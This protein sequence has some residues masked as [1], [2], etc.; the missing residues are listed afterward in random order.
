MKANRRA[1]AVL[2]FLLAAVA[3]VAAAQENVWAS[4]GPTG[5]G[6]VG[7]L[8]IAGGV[9]YAA[10]ENGV[11][12]SNDGGATWQQSGLAGE[13]QQVLALPQAVF[14]LTGS[15]NKSQPK[16]FRV[17]RDGGKTWGLVPGLSSI[18]AA[19][20]DPWQLSTLYAG[21]ANGTIWRSSDA[22]AS[23]QQIS[24]SPTG[25]AAIAFEFDSRAIYVRSLDASIGSYRNYKSLD[26]G[27]SWDAIQSDLEVLTGGSA[28]GVVYARFVTA[29]GEQGFCRSADSAA[30][31]KCSSIRGSVDLIFEVPGSAPGE[32]S[33]SLA[34]YWAT[35]DYGLHVS[36]DGG[37]TWTSTAGKLGSSVYAIASDATGSLLLAGTSAGIFRS[38]DRGDSWTPSSAGLRLPMTMHSL[39]LDP[40]NPSTVWAGTPEAGV[41]RSSDGGLSWS[42]A[43]GQGEM[44]VERSLAV[45]PELSSTLYAWTTSGVS[46]SDDGGATWSSPSLPG[47]SSQ[48]SYFRNALAVDPASSGRVWAANWS[49]GLFRS[50]DGARTWEPR[51]IAQDVFC[52]LFDEKRPGTIYLGSYYDTDYN[53]LSGLVGG[54]IF[55]SRDSG[56]SFTKFTVN[57]GRAFGND[58]TSIAA[59]PFDDNVLYAGTRTGVYRSADAGRTWQALGSLRTDALVAD[60]VRPGTLYATTFAGVLRTTDGAQSWHA[61]SAGLGSIGVGP[62]VISPNGK[63]LH[64]GTERR[65][66]LRAQ[67][68]G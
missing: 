36:D 39:A 43:G 20:V 66:S 41:F 62:L 52:I 65:R 35:D 59:D 4:H 25:S 42:P 30:N 5:P 60:P 14:A 27:A 24:T 48:G 58:V 16:D 44:L 23:W 56:A 32:A 33:R 29:W 57:Q 64:V 21:A 6:Y 31:W 46:R 63:W 3:A 34:T 53:T 10:T 51:S 18:V 7:D 54:S 17:S 2:A 11:F 13:T 1:P 55:V 15:F 61:F 67:P 45:D 37:A 68:G 26:G 28:P 8:A 22:G 50:D 12:L 47:R 40:Q 49:S 19:A 9:A 38:V